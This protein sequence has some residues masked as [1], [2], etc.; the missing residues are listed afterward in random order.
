MKFMSVE[1][2]EAFHLDDRSFHPCMISKISGVRRKVA[3]AFC[4]LSPVT[5]TRSKS[6]M[7]HSTLP[8][9]NSY[10]SKE[11]IKGKTDA[12]DLVHSIDSLKSKMQLSCPREQRERALHRL[13]L[14]RQTISPAQDQGKIFDIKSVMEGN[15]NL[16][17]LTRFFDALREE[18]FVEK[19]Q[20]SMS[21]MPW[22]ASLASI[23]EEPHEF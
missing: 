16:E 15:K 20:D 17:E 4:F 1:H 7:N 2:L 8:N 12:E 22:N 18:R 3:L 21:T 10:A 19:M 13:G 5:Q 9:A 14:L 11:K 23:H 6:K